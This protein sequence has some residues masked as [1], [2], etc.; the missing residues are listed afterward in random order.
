MS[1][2]YNNSIKHFKSLIVKAERI[3]VCMQ[4]CRKYETQA[5]KILPPIAN[6]DTL[7]MH[8]LAAREPLPF[9]LVRTFSLHS[10]HFFFL[11]YS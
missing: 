4:T 1:K 10:T 11:F 3:L 2:E 8:V 6:Q 7:P 9:D 5:E